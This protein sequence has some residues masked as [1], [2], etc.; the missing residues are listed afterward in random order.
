M[1]YKLGDRVMVSQVGLRRLAHPV[2]ASV[3]RLHEDL[4]EADVRL[5]EEADD[6]EGGHY[7]VWTTVPV[8]VEAL[9]PCRGSDAAA[10]H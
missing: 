4:G 2:L 1:D 9:E 7:R 8:L 6:E 3:R 10:P 5:L